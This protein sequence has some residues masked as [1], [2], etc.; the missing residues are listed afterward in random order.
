MKS[1]KKTTAFLKVTVSLAQILYL[2]SEKKLPC[3]QT[4]IHQKPLVFILMLISR[5]C[6]DSLSCCLNNF[7]LIHT[8]FLYIFL[9][10]FSYQTNTTRETL[11]TILNIQPKD[12]GT[13]SGE[14]REQVVTKQAIEMLSK[15]PSNYVPHEVWKSI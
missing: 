14:T 11:E 1:S 15:L 8:F 5:M 7:C 6:N 12:S 13:G 2:S 10:F 3:Y 9:F 4:W